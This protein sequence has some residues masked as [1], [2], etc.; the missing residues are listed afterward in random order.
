MITMQ[1]QNSTSTTDAPHI[2]LIPLYM[3]AP[4]DLSLRK[5]NIIYI[6]ICILTS[7]TNKYY[8][9]NKY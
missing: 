2:I 9:K 4:Y 5:L 7:L 1:L 8:T 3:S 6:V